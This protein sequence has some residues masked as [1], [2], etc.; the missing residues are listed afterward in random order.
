M[1]NHIKIFRN[2]TMTCF[3]STL[4]IPSFTNNFSHDL[5]S[6]SNY[7]FS[8]K[9][10]LKESGTLIMISIKSRRCKSVS[11]AYKLTFFAENNVVYL[12][13]RV[14]HENAKKKA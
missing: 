13:K 1:S 7:T 5:I 3:E 10:A 6:D 8:H 14:T 4:I 12:N 2:L 9:V 11:L